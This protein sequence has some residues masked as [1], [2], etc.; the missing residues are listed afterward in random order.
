[1][2]NLKDTQMKKILLAAG[3]MLLAVVGF[4]AY[5]MMQSASMEMGGG[6]DMSTTRNTVADHFVVSIKPE[7]PE[8][9]RND[10]HAWI[11]TVKTTDGAL[12]E[13]ATIA[14]DGGMPMHG[15]GLPTNPEMTQY[16]GQGQYKIDGVRF[17]MDG[18]WEFKL[19]ITANGVTDNVTFNLKF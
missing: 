1:L 6:L 4:M 9:R 12:V 14:I 18:M 13:N 17:N 11:A 3:I 8:F 15:H 10:L 16:L 7:N 5:K 19:A 2:L